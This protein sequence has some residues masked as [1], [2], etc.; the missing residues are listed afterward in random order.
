M[1][2]AVFLITVGICYAGYEAKG[3]AGDY[4]VTVTFDKSKP[5]EGMNEMEISVVDQASRPV[6]DA[7]VQV[8]YLMPSLG[9][10]TPMMDH[11]TTARPMGNKYRAALDFTMAGEWNVVVSITKAKRTGKMEFGLVITK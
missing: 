9:G 2:V 8:E 5:A 6:T 1:I 4:A 3:K 7:E 11:K 10:K